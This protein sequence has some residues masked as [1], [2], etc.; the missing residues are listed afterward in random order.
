MRHFLAVL[1]SC[2]HAS[3]EGQ[4]HAVACRLN[5]ATAAIIIPIK[6]NCWSVA[7]RL[8]AR[9]PAVCCSYLLKY[10]PTGG[11]KTRCHVG[12]LVLGESLVMIKDN[13]N[14]VRHLSQLTTSLFFHCSKAVTNI[15]VHVIWI[16]IRSFGFFNWNILPA[17]LWP[18]GLLSP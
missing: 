17:E 1:P 15:S 3:G 5:A 2:S 9:I 16:P 4:T 10:V 13:R 12:N 18:W 8:H 11:P 7:Q 14:S 6:A